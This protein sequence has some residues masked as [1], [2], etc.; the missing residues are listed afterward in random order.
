MFFQTQPHRRSLERD[1]RDLPCDLDL[2]LRRRD[3][4]RLLDLR[5]RC[6]DRE[7]LRDRLPVNAFTQ[8]TSNFNV[9]NFKSNYCTTRWG[10]GERL[11]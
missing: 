3:L 8:R 1:L 9:S 4:S 11:R 10:S 2:D 6:R 7:R 5:R